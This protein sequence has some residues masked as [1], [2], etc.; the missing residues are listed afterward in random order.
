MKSY[1]IL[2]EDNLIKIIQLIANLKSSPAAWYDL[3]VH[4][5]PILRVERE[6]FDTLDCQLRKQTV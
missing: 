5:V 1:D 2:N 4:S 3:L 6:I